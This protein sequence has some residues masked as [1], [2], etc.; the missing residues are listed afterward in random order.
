MALR[1]LVAACRAV[2]QTANWESYR[3]RPGAVVHAVKL[4][5]PAAMSAVV[6]DF[7]FPET[8]G[9]IL[10]ATIST[11][12]SSRDAVAPHPFRGL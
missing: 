6:G 10:H 3:H 1:F 12:E 11:V 9:R 8:A 2:A 5:D 4:G 7:P